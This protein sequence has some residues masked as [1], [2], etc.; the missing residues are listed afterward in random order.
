MTTNIDLIPFPAHLRESIMQSV[1]HRGEMNGLTANWSAE[2]GFDL[3]LTAEWRGII[4]GTRH[5]DL[6]PYHRTRQLRFKQKND[7]IIGLRCKDDIPYWSLEEL[8][9]I[10]TLCDRY[11]ANAIDSGTGLTL[12]QELDLELALQ[13]PLSIYNLVITDHW[14]IYDSSV[15][16][17]FAES[18]LQMK[19]RQKYGLADEIRFG[20][21]AREIAVL[22]AKY[23]ELT[24]NDFV[25]L[26]RR[27]EKRYTRFCQTC[28]LDVTGLK[29]CS[30]CKN[31]RYCSY[32]CQSLDW[33]NHRLSCNK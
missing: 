1:I 13:D 6:M 16:Q 23:T 25:T 32:I 17:S 31:V 12:D 15:N 11:S 14:E 2:R 26:C 22:R 9:K 24:P 5:F 21:F 28:N 30:R 4:Q 33:Q 18:D 8:Q 3:P 19:L 7:M 20:L 10:K 27:V 29:K